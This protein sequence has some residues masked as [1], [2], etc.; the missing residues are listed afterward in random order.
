MAFKSASS[1]AVTGSSTIT[2]NAPAGIVNG[3]QLIVGLYATVTGS[4]DR[5]TANWGWIPL[6]SPISADGMGQVLFV[7][8]R[9][10]LNEPTTYSFDVQRLS[11]SSW[12]PETN[13]K[14]VIVAAYDSTVPLC[15]SLFQFTQAAFTAGPGTKNA[16][17]GAIGGGNP[18]AAMITPH[19]GVIARANTIGTTNTPGWDVAYTQRA[20]VDMPGLL[21]RLYLHDETLAST[22][23]PAHTNQDVESSAA[24][25]DIISTRIYGGQTTGSPLTPPS[26]IL[27]NPPN[28]ANMHWA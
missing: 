19:F 22:N 21:S 9:T 8:T 23:V 10:A 20:T 16:N 14:T 2:V 12:G 1:A 18:L 5:V 27:G 28:W 3:D 13:D 17:N 25:F 11:G 26:S 6:G 24:L 7:F 4:G 15:A